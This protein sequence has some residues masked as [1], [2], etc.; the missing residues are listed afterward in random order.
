MDARQRSLLLR[1]LLHIASPS[2]HRAAGPSTLRGIYGARRRRR[3]RPSLACRS[4]PAETP[5]VPV[6]DVPPSA[7]R[8]RLRRA[9]PSNAWRARV[10]SR[11]PRREH[12][13]RAGGMQRCVAGRERAPIENRLRVAH[14]ANRC[15]SSFRSVT[16]ETETPR[17][18]VSR[19]APARST[20]PRRSGSPVGALGLERLGWNHRYA[21]ADLRREHLPGPL[22][23]AYVAV[24]QPVLTANRTIHG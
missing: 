4:F 5:R 21:S 14:A 2:S 6:Q 7:P 23:T 24:T 16:H 10:V 1:R 11:D 18:D 17:W 20:T 8:R 22:Q 19:A 3:L 15:C 9:Q 12:L 13:Q